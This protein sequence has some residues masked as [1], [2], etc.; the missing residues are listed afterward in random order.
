ME[1]VAFCYIYRHLCGDGDGVVVEH[2][3]LDGVVAGSPV[4][5]R[6]EDKLGQLVG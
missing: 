6:L 3:F 2:E 5:D 1:E 4:F